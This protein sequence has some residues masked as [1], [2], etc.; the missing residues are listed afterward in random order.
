MCESYRVRPTNAL[1]YLAAMAL[2]LATMMAAIAVAASAWDPVRDATVTPVTE[3]VDA[4][5]SSLAIYTDILQTDR[6]ISCRGRYGDGDKGRVE[7][8]DK[9]VDITAQG[10]GTKWTL[11][12]LLEKGRDGL[13]I[14]CTPADQR[15]DNAAYG[16]ATVTGYSSA[17]NNGKGIASIGLSIAAGFGGWVFWSRRAARR[18]ARFAAASSDG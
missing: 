5:G 2:A 16:Y 1:W 12:G 14:V 8:P 11:I 15:V 18:D 6:H 17:V 13:R 4:G 7:I 9:G 3:R 10:D